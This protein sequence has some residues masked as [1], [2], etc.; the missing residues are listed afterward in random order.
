MSVLVCILGSGT[1]RP[2][3]MFALNSF[4]PC[5]PWALSSQ[6]LMAG[7]QVLGG[8][9]ERELELPADLLIPPKSE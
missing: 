6:G 1:C 9:L 8:A 5:L 3:Q 2:K 4:E 7:D